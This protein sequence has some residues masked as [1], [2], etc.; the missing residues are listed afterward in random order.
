MRESRWYQRRLSAGR[1][2]PRPDWGDA[3]V[4][5]SVGRVRAMPERNPVVAAPLLDDGPRVTPMRHVW[6][7]QR[8]QLIHAPAPTQP[9]SRRARRWSGLDPMLPHR[10]KSALVKKEMRVFQSLVGPIS[11]LTDCWNRRVSWRPNAWWLNVH[12]ARRRWRM[13]R[14]PTSLPKASV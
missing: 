13:S 10:Q 5:A 12:L 3:F 14:R 7:Q 11:T 4:L 6:L 2:M 8:L 9:I 1:L